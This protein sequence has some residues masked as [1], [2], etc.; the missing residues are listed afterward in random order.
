MASAASEATSLL[1]S[2][3]PSS[4]KP[5]KPSRNVTFNPQVSTSSRRAEN[6]TFPRQP[7]VPPVLSPLPSSRVAMALPSPCFPLSTPSSAHATALALCCNMCPKS[8]LTRPGAAEDAE[9]AWRDIQ[10]SAAVPPRQRFLEEYAAALR[11]QVKTRSE[12]K[13]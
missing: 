9:A 2:H 12:R 8:L 3:F 10:K 7:P 5:P 11:Q 4:T 1:P 13:P 6:P